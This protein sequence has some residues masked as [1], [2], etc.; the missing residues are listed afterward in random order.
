MDKRVPFEEHA[1]SPI[2]LAPS[3][4]YELHY[5]WGIWQSLQNKWLYKYHKILKK[6][7]TPNKL[8]HNSIIIHFKLNLCF[9]CEF[10]SPG[11]KKKDSS[12][13]RNRYKNYTSIFSIVQFSH[14]SEGSKSYQ[15][16]TIVE[17][18]NRVNRRKRNNVTRMIW[19]PSVA[20][21][22]FSKLM[23]FNGCHVFL[24]VSR[25]K[26]YKNFSEFSWFKFWILYGM[27]IYN[28]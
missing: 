18:N 11:K 20:S 21:D 26:N 17:V 7:M 16:K 24:S 27:R 3:Y 15:T 28:D 8:S 2:C 6:I 12:V 23:R 14:T 25:G 10:V 9:H 19:A 13:I 1:P 22:T 5:C 4:R